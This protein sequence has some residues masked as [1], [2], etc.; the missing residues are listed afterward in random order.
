MTA[1][2]QR[3]RGTAWQNNQS[4]ASHIKALL[5]ALKPI[6]QESREAR[7]P[8]AVGDIQ[9]FPPPNDAVQQ[10]LFAVHSHPTNPPILFSVPRGDRLPNRPNSHPNS[11]MLFSDHQ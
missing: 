1:C 6:I 11:H 3:R 10:M 2:T 9:R 4:G 7:E 8:L 5:L